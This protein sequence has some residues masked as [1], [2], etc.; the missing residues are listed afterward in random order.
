MK[1]N[2]GVLYTEG[3]DWDDQSVHAWSIN[4]L[5]TSCGIKN[6]LKQGDALSPSI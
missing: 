2:G 6:G 1:Y 5:S 4:K 3:T